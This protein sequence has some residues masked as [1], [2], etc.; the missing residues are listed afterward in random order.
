MKATKTMPIDV[1]NRRLVQLIKE[2]EEIIIDKERTIIEDE[3]RGV[4]SNEWEDTYFS[5]EL[6]KYDFCIDE[7]NI[8]LNLLKAIK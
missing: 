7:F 8:I 3:E 5:S 2:R 6:Y 1:V 4:P